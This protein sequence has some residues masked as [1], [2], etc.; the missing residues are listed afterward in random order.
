[1]DKLLLYEN[2][3]LKKKIECS[4]IN[5]KFIFLDDFKDYISIDEIYRYLLGL[6]KNQYKNIW[7]FIVIKW[8]EMKTKLKKDEQFNQSKY[9]QM[10]YKQIH[11]NIEIIELEELMNNF[12]DSDK[13]KL[14]FLLNSIIL[15]LS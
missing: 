6:D 12:I 9:Q 3:K 1:M 8:I 2:N 15:Y 11:K 7:N 4:K 10:D 14:I 13:M 5:Y